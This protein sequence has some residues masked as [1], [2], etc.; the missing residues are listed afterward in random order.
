MARKGWSTYWRLEEKYRKVLERYSFEN[1]WEFQV[2]KTIHKDMKMIK[3]SKS[4]MWP[5]TAY[6]P[7]PHQKSI[8]GDMSDISPEELRYLKYTSPE[9]EYV[10]YEKLLEEDYKYM[11]RHLRR[12]WANQGAGHDSDENVC[13]GADDLMMY[14]VKEV[15]ISGASMINFRPD[16][17]SNLKQGLRLTVCNVL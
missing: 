11:R 6:S 16:I 5:F 7:Y 14:L 3:C 17:Q 12:D 10:A 13:D 8:P 2:L 15:Y 9:D 4:R 1:T